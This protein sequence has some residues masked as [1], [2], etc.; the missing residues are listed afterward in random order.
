MPH[1]AAGDGSGHAPKPKW[2]RASLRAK[3]VAVLAVPM[4]ALFGA[5]FAV[6][7]VESDVDAAD[8]SV[9]RF[10]G[11]RG[12]LG[13]VHSSLLDSETAI[14]GYAATGEQRFLDIHEKARGAIAAALDQV[15]ARTA[16]DAQATASLA[17]IRR[18]AADEFRLLD[19][20]RDLGPK[21]KDAASLLER[22]KAGMGDL[23]ASVGLLNEYEERRFTSARYD[24]DVARRRLFRTV[25]LCGTL[26]PLG[27]LFIH[28]LIAGRM[29]RRLQ[30]VQ[31]N[32]RRLAHGL[33]LAPL[34]PGTDE[35]AALGSQL[36]NAAYLLQ[37]RERELSESERRHR[38]LF[39]RAPIPYEEMDRNGAITR[40]NQA[41]CSLLKCTPE[42]MA[43]KR[44]WDFLAP[45]LQEEAR[46]AL[47]QRM[48]T[49]EERGAFE[50][51][52]LLD[53]G[54]H[55]TVEIRESLIHNERGEVTGMIRSLLDVTERNLAAVAARKVEQYALELRNKNEQLAQAL[56]TARSAT[57][58][59][60]RFL[61]SVSHEL[62]TPLNGIIGFSE[63]LYDRKLGQ[64]SEDQVDVM[65]D[66]LTSAR[67]LLQLIN[68]ILDLSKVEAGHMEFRPERSAIAQ[69][70]FE[71]R[72]VVRP[73]ADKKNL[74]L[75]TE[76][77]GDLV[78]NLDP[79]RFKQVLYNYL[80]NAVKFTA[81]GGRITVRIARQG[82]SSLRVDVEDTGIGI[83]ADEMPRLF[84]EFSQL[85]NSRKAEQGT[86]LGLA[87]TRHI[88]EAQGGNVAVRSTL[89]HGSV[90]SAVLPL[91]S[92]NRTAAG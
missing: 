39:D 36:E 10:Y 11:I 54:S 51:E 65:G 86:G 58:A 56:K 71:V 40:F 64:L 79:G 27:A 63:L 73:L 52:Y 13:E 3:G 37:A 76:V 57:A 45:E 91:D 74:H 14:A 50:C 75:A 59:K 84:Q 92:A 81:D 2:W 35:I 7:W 38:D 33:P 82:D 18:A 69:L 26:G 70:L 42:Q 23:Q 28:V 5:L 17:E 55:L 25:M 46:T 24:R 6:R 47:G 49:G 12:E 22:E 21:S 80:S 60:S 61:A 53:D 77:P 44:A 4:A 83:A 67:H 68:D 87:L 30:A 15:A 72:D 41:V 19:Q 66:I 20:I 32:A 29:V 62:R 8:T 34:R 90:F 48:R 31:E 1:P 43:G 89:G 9:V 85:P 78:A 88:V 16:G